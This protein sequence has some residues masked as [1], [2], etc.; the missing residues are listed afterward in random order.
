MGGV[1]EL[2]QDDAAGVANFN[3]ADESY[4]IKKAEGKNAA[5]AR[6]RRHF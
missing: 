4:L 5:G 6:R 3:S 1:D 2:I